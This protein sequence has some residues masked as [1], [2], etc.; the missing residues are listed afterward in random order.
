MLHAE[1]PQYEGMD[2]YDAF[3]LDWDTYNNNEPFWGAVHDM[4]LVKLSTDAGFAADQVFQVMTPSAIE[5]AQSRTQLLQGG[6]FAGAGVWFLYGALKA[7]A[8]AA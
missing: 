4:D 2:P 5:E 6:D 7:P 3:M 8:A 1:V